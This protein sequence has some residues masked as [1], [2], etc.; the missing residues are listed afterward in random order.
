MK[1]FLYSP[2]FSTRLHTQI[3]PTTR[4]PAAAFGPQGGHTD[5]S[6][7]PLHGWAAGDAAGWE[8]LIA[9]FELQLPSKP[10]DASPGLPGCVGTAGDS[11]HRDRLHWCRPACQGQQGRNP[12][13]N[14]AVGAGVQGQA[15]HPQ[16]PTFHPKSLSP[17]GSCV[18]ALI[19][20]HHRSVA[21]HQ[22]FACGAPRR[23]TNALLALFILLYLYYYIRNLQTFALLAV[24]WLF[25]SES[26]LLSLQSHPQQCP[27]PSSPSRTRGNCSLDRHRA[28]RFMRQSQTDSGKPSS[29]SRRKMILRQ[30]YIF[31]D[32]YGYWSQVP[33]PAEHRRGIIFFLLKEWKDPT[34]I[35]SFIT[36]QKNLPTTETMTVW[37]ITLP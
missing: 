36:T 29:R 21:S 2:L 34:L 12:Q 20:P 24:C 25:I 37:I 11:R 26:A 22:H 9:K 28:V 32:L 27:T 35:L 23:A 18:W 19:A 6:P 5:L 17:D 14:A 30:Y 15:W 16:E 31:T 13:Q 7:S 8:V 3:K 33:R 4:T 10:G 1:A